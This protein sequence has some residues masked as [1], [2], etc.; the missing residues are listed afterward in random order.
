MFASTGIRCIM[1]FWAMTALASPAL[2][3]GPK[4]ID[5]DCDS[6]RG[7][8]ISRALERIRDGGIIEIKG[9]CVESLVIERPVTL[10]GV[11]DASLGPVAPGDVTIVVQSRNV[12]ISG[13]VL[14]S[15]AL[16]QIAYQNQATGEISKNVIGGAERGLVIAE[17][18]SVR[19]VDNTIRMT[20]TA[21]LALENST[22]RI[23]FVELTDTTSRPNRIAANRLGILVFGSATADVRANEFEDNSTSVIAA[24][25]VLAGVPLPPPGVATFCEDLTSP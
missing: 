1:I 19:I 14:E 3:T 9:S 22:A 12:T 20:D 8:T 24:S 11:G 16:A 4:S 6:R 5:V 18:S 21:I 15:P 23:G 2:A 17:G 10:R 25:G 7:D 13:L